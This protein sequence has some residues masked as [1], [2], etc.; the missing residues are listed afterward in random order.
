MVSGPNGKAYL[1]EHPGIP[2]FEFKKGDKWLLAVICGGTANGTG[3]DKLTEEDLKYVFLLVEKG[4]RPA[5]LPKGPHVVESDSTEHDEWTLF[6]IRIL[7]YVDRVR[8]KKAE[9]TAE[10]RAT[11]SRLFQA[12]KSRMT[13]ELGCM[14]KVLH[15]NDSCTQEKSRG[16]I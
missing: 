8:P 15:S 16:S 12:A 1:A 11:I 2:A 7:K 14:T 6:D 13:V 10:S 3:L 9:I 5:N 4:S